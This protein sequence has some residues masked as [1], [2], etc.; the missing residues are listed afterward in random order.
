MEEEPVPVE[1]EPAVVAEPEP[2]VVESKSFHQVVKDQ[3]IAGGPE[4]MGIVL[5]ICLIL[6]LAVAIE[7][8]IHLNHCNY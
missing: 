8:I 6:G 3:F 4:F 1:E 2:E 5:L 7:R